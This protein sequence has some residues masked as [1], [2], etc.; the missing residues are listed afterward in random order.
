M[1]DNRIGMPTMTKYYAAYGSNLCKMQMKQRCPKAIALGGFELPSAQLVFNGVADVIFHKTKTAMIGLW[2]ITDECEK[3]LDM[4]E[5]VN[6]TGGGA[7]RKEIVKVTLDGVVV[8]ALIYVMNRSTRKMPMLS[9]LNIISE[10]FKDFGLDPKWLSAALVD[11]REMAAAQEIKWAKE[12]AERARA[13]KKQPHQHQRSPHHGITDRYDGP[14]Y[15]RAQADYYDRTRGVEPDQVIWDDVPAFDDAAGIERMRLEA[16]AEFE[17]FDE[18]TYTEPKRPT[19]PTPLQVV[20]ELNR[21]APR[22]LRTKE[23]YRAASDKL[24]RHNKSGYKLPARKGPH[25]FD[26]PSPH[27]RARK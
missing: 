1:G 14:S 23:D 22:R 21:Q 27:H 18:E 3:S 5:G 15:S 16:E 25:L 24:E 19:R 17:N 4:F 2:K 6:R 8:D 12:A 11:T 20:N 13:P 10:G 26:E 9:Y 7:Y